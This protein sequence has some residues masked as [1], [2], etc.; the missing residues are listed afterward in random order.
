M[1]VFAFTSAPNSNPSRL[2]AHLAIYIL[3]VACA[4]PYF[5]KP[6]RSAGFTNFETEPVQPLG[7]SADDGLRSWS[8]RRP[9]VDRR[10]PP[11]P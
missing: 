2:I 11:P 5:Q 6:E 10:P 8:S 1:H 4:S 7:L 9:R 3:V